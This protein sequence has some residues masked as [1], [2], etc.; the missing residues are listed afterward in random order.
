MDSEN[1]KLLGD[2]KER[3]NVGN[4]QYKIEIEMIRKKVFNENLKEEVI[5]Y[6]S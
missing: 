1:I 6:Y 2:S 3:K 5:K 4:N